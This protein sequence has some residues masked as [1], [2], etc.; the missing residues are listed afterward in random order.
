MA[1]HKA[2]PFAPVQIPVSSASGGVR[3]GVDINRSS[4]LE[5]VMNN[6]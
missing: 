2:R 4:E 3:P 5:E 6:S 1:E